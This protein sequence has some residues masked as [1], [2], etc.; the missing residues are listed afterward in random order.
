MKKTSLTF[1]KNL[2]HSISP[3][4]FE[5][6]AARV[7]EKEAKTFADNVTRDSHGNTSAVIN[8][9]GS[10]RIMFAGHT[11]EIGF[12]ITHIDDQ[13]FLRIGAVGGWDPQIAQGQRV[14]IRG[15]DGHVPGV[16]GKC[17]I[18]LMSPEER[19][20]VMEI[21][22]MWVDIGARDRAAALKKV[23]IGDPLVLADRF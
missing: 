5:E 6:E 23:S 20:K 2:V 4:G 21:K 17:P 12:L 13:G 9:G 22:D 14:V 11:D 15:N 1:L 3:S 7:W 8:R 18:H 10:P 19:K 16:M